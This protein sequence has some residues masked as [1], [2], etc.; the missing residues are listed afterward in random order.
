[1]DIN[2]FSFNK[3]EKRFHTE[4]DGYKIYIFE[5][6]MS[7]EAINR[8]QKIMD[9]YPQRIEPI[10]EY[11]MKDEKFISNV[12]GLKKDEIVEMLP[13][14]MIFIYKSGGGLSYSIAE[15]QNGFFEFDFEGALELETFNNLVVYEKD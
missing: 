10:V 14:P 13:K 12:R 8:A 6:F 4:K 7:D 9:L 1:M 3:K 5:R 11:L 15:F 2:S